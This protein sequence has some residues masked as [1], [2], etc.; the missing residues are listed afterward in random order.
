MKVLNLRNSFPSNQIIINII[1]FSTRSEGDVIPF[2]TPNMG[3]VSS[4]LQTFSNSL[5]CSQPGEFIITSLQNQ[6]ISG[7]FNFKA[8]ESV[9]FTS[10]N[11]TEGVFNNLIY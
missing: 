1:G 2:S 11:V 3:T 10:V 6:Q 8:T 4:G 5:S 9:S 7:T